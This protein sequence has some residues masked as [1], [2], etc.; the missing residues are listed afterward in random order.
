M[1]GAARPGDATLPLLAARSVAVYALSL[2]AAASALL[3][4]SRADAGMLA[5]AAAGLAIAQ[6]AGESFGGAVDSGLEGTSRLRLRITFATAYGGLVVLALTAAV[7]SGEPRL[8]GQ[9]T[10]VFTVLQA[11]FLLLAD[12]GRSQL[13]PVANALVLVVLASLGGGVVA[14]A[15]VVGGLALLGFFLALDH[16]ARVL[17]AYP[18]GPAAL[19]AA[20]LRRAATSLAPIVIGL[21]VLFFVSPPAP[22]AQVRLPASSGPRDEDVSAAYRRLV[23]FGLAGSGL[24]FAAVRLL[25]RD[26]GA[27]STLEE[28]LPLERGTEEALPEPPPLVRPDYQGRRGRIVRAYVSVLARARE[29]G[30]RSR[31]SQTPRDI[32]MQ[33][34]A[35]PGPLGTLTELFVGARYGPDEPSEEQVVAAER[36]GHAVAAGLGRTKRV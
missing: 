31:P 11:A 16:A 26:R 10:M 17:Q 1:N 5:L 9:E 7:G 34:P 29:T 28:A 25:R 14:A 22:L 21:T 33:L 6:V 8:I 27:R 36:A 18:A 3:A 13:G 15:A 32:A 19:L 24:I 12:L 20:T 4:W 30:F 35:P 2:H 23:V